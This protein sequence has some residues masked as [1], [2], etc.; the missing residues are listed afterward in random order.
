MESPVSVPVSEEVWLRTLDLLRESVSERDFEAWLSPVRYVGFE[1]ETRHLTLSVA[2]AF[3]KRWVDRKFL[4]PIRAAVQDTVGYA[5]SVELLIVNEDSDFD[6][7][8]RDGDLFM[9]KPQPETPFP[10]NGHSRS[11]EAQVQPVQTSA[12]SRAP[13]AE[14]L[15]AWNPASEQQKTPQPFPHHGEQRPESYADLSVEDRPRL[16]QRYTFSEFVVG[17]S[18]RYAHAAAQSVADAHSQAFNPLFL[19]GSS[20]LGKTHLMQA[21]GHAIWDNDRSKRVL[22]VSSEQFTNSLVESI[23]KKRTIDFRNEFRKVDLLLLDDVQFLMGK[24]QT[25]QEVFHTFNALFDAGKKIVL[26]SDRPPKE[27]AT[28][29]ERLRSRF[30][31]GV[32][33]DI[34]PPDLETRIAIL[35]SKAQAIRLPIP[36]EA[37]AYIAERI[38]S[39]IR[40]LEGVLKHI[41]VRA[42]L[43]KTAVTMDMCREVISHLNVGG[44]A[45]KVSVEDIQKAVCDY[46]DVSL[47]DLLGG[48]RTKKLTTPRHIALYLCRELTDLSFPDLAQRFG[49]RDHTTIIY[50]YRKIKKCIAEDEK[51]GSIVDHLQKVSTRGRE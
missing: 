32:I 14:S 4:D 48:R 15:P 24:E 3:Y 44:P 25:Q 42:D 19:Y 36:N 5:V 16:N 30:E 34:Q 13:Q 39:N 21:I 20:G 35:R 1:E 43:D 31:W 28:L 26:T 47:D 27:L 45:E 38:K 11:P 10:R 41:R 12:P 18:N 9:A 7:G 46:F 17:E 40:E 22:Y 50:G 51:L 33:A 49:G 29:E 8:G 2:N 23:L 37:L 6:R